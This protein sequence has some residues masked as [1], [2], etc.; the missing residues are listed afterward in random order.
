MGGT[1]H[2]EQL[3]AKNDGQTQSSEEKDQAGVIWRTGRMNKHSLQKIW[4]QTKKCIHV[5]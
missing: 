5:I 3:R 2:R 1:G 4:R